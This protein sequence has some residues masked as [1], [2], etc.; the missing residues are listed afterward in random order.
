MSMRKNLHWIDHLK[1]I[2][3]FLVVY[4]HALSLSPIIKNAIYTFHL[5]VFLAVTGFLGASVLLDKKSSARFVAQTKY[6]AN[7]YFFFSILASIVWYLLEARSES[8]LKLIDP[9]IGAVYG[10]HGPKLKLIHNNDPLWY[11]P[12]LISSTALIFLFARLSWVWMAISVPLIACISLWMKWPPLAWSIDIAPLGALF[13]GVGVALRRAHDGGLGLFEKIT[14]TRMTWLFVFIWVLGVLFNGAVNINSR[15]W[16]NSWIVFLICSVSG[17]L[18]LFSIVRKMPMS[19]L[20]SNL[21]KHTLVIFCI[22][23]Y[24]TKIVVRLT[25]EIPG[26]YQDALVFIFA[27]LITMVCYK[28][29]VIVQPVLVKWMKPTVVLK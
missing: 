2:C 25:P 3:I 8:V 22:H 16:G 11:F 20:S 18:A 19:S 5:P 29:S 23:I 10:L 12:F 26:A 28:V 6:Y 7:L 15:V 1:S 4:G 24:L 27:L 13:I 21:A 9:L 17:V 14:S